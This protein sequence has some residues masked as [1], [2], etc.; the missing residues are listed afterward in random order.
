MTQEELQSRIA[1]A[2]NGRGRTRYSEEVRRAATEFARDERAAG[3]SL[4]TVAGALGLNSWT[5]QRWYHRARQERNTTP[6][7]IG[8]LAFVRLEPTI[9]PTMIP[10]EL[11]LTSGAI[12]RVPVGF[13]AQTLS[14]VL[15]LVVGGPR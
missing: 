15:A 14:R 5:L 3:K 6:K 9:A 2:K 13:D 7:S 1:A 10:L 8:P 12:V 4:E 11:V